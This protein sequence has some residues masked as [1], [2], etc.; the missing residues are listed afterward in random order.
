MSIENPNQT[1]AREIVRR[2]ISPGEAR[3]VLFGS[4]ARG[5]ARAFSDIDLAIFPQADFSPGKLAA[6]REALE[7]SSLLVDVDL[8]D[9][10]TADPRLV[11]AVEREGQVWIA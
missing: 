4:R 1:M 3:V 8:V 11:A 5:D 2:M 7:E 10:R 9:M 6:L